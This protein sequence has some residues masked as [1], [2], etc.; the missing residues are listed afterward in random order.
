MKWMLQAAS[1]MILLRADEAS[2]P[3]AGKGKGHGVVR[4]DA[5]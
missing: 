5:L 2:S 4:H 1:G 3:R